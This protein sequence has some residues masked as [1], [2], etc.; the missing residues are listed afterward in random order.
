MLQIGE[1]RILIAKAVII[2][3]QV[4]FIVIDET[5]GLVVFQDFRLFRFAVP[6]QKRGEGPDAGLANIRHHK[7]IRTGH[8]LCIH[9]PCNT[10]SACTSPSRATIVSTPHSMLALT[11]QAAG[12]AAVGKSFFL[13]ILCSRA[14]ELLDTSWEANFRQIEIGSP[15]LKVHCP[16]ATHQAGRS[17]LIW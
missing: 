9:V 12:K 15:G 13:S 11:A 16:P 8:I 17:S 7:E 4:V 1:N 6:L 10:Q 3:D 2:T 5:L 14:L